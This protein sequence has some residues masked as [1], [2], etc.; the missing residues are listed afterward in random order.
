MYHTL[1]RIAL[2]VYVFLGS[3]AIQAEM[4]QFQ[5]SL[6]EFVGICLLIKT[7]LFRVLGG[8]VELEEL[9]PDVFRFKKWFSGL[10]R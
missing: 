4:Q 6:K 10:Y 1:F 3:V 5:N 8:V 7:K 2:A 9:P